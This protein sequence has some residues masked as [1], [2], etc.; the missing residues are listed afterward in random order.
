MKPLR[1]VTLKNNGG[2]DQQAQSV[3]RLGEKHS[4]L[5]GQNYVIHIL[6]RQNIE[7]GELEIKKIGDKFQSNDDFILH[8]YIR[9]ARGN[10]ITDTIQEFEPPLLG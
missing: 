6:K 4:I 10:Q 9:N 5:F 7:S 2:Q 3:P 8:N 1:E